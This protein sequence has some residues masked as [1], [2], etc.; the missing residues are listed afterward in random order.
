MKAALQKSSFLSRVASI[1]R[2]FAYPLRISN[3]LELINPL[4]SS[5]RLMARVVKVWD[6]TKNARTLTLRPG[7]HWKPHRAGQYVSIRIP[8]A[9]KLETRYY[10]ISSPPERT[11]GCFTITVKAVEGGRGSHSLVRDLRVGAYL[12]IGLP[13]GD[14]V[15][16]DPVPEKLLF[17]TGGI[18]ITPA[19]SMLGSLIARK[20]L[21]DSVHL[22]YSPNEFEVVFDRQLKEMARTHPQYRLARVFTRPADGIASLNEGHFS[23]AQLD[24]LCPDW[25]DR[26]VFA[27]GPETMLT[28]L[29]THFERTRMAA[30]LHLERFGFGPL[31]VPVEG[32]GGHV[33]LVKS[34]LEVEAD[35]STNLLRV[36][37]QAGLKPKHGCRQGICHTCNVRLISGS[38]RDLRTGKI[39]DDL[40]GPVQICVSAAAGNCELDL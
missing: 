39:F 21:P 16:P 12:P 27:C 35:A 13:D 15:L 40:G 32:V 24:K 14:F 5:H 36:A 37:E 22:H 33:R 20:C 1:P 26:E 29:T 2:L 28:A 3:Y 31:N 23:P 19:M 8:V 34:G 6:E 9:G 18:G 17:I 25:K 11:D 38:V 10:T 30:K 4:W 7:R